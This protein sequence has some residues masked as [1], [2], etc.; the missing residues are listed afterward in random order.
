MPM[1][2]AV[3]QFRE[4]TDE[5]LAFTNQ[6]GIK[7]ILM[8]I[9]TLPGEKQWEYM[10]L[11][12][13]VSKARDAGIRLTAIENTPKT[14]FDKAM[15]GLPG[16]DEQ[17]EHY[18][19]TIR[20]VGRAGIP[21]FG[22]NWMPSGVWRTSRTT[23]GRGCA[24]VTSFDMELVKNAPLTYGREFTADEM[25]ANYEYFIKAVLPVAE[26]EGV[27][28]ALHPDDP[29]VPSLGGVAR[30]FSS[31]EGFKWAME[32]A[33]SKYHG[34]DFCQG[35]WT[36]MVYERDSTGRGPGLF[37]AI[38]Y[39]GSRGKIVYVHFRNVLGTVPRFRE[40]F[41]NEGDV[42][43]F[44]ALKA[45]KEAGFDG[46]LIDDHVPHMVN[47]TPWG[48]RSRAYAIGY[49]QALLDVMNQL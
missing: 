37:D 46:F 47:D 33:P 42:N 10:D 48:H 43:M 13:L 16:R 49:I 45:Y 30:I 26:E 17:I 19:N 23:P 36:E 41:I 3:G 39:F 24:L 6:L 20:N 29:P 40:G 11:L 9:P 44:Q 35:C 4:L 2:L 31:F 27:T 14:F 7:D 12:M 1:R 34:L 5:M 8:N 15:L 32:V 21:I 38:S 28:L 22:H 18:R 25:K